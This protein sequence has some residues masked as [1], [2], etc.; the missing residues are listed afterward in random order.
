[1]PLTGWDEPP[2]L[3]NET[4]HS[5]V[6]PAHAASNRQRGAAGKSQNAA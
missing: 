4:T 5:S 1:M 2:N 3:I 6:F